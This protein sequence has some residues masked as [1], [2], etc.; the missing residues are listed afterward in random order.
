MGETSK[1]IQAVFKL[2][3]EEDAVLFFDE[4]DTEPYRVCRR[5]FY[6]S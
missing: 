2:A 5:F 4:A 3:S 1:N 6:L